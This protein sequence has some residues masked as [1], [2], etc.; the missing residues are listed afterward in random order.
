M[1]KAVLDTNVIISGALWLGI[2][3]VT[4]RHF[5]NILKQSS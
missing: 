3:I 1:I 5:L 2:P 4:P